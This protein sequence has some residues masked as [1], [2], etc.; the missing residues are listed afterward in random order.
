M[1][2]HL[3]N[4]VLGVQEKFETFIQFPSRD[5]ENVVEKRGAGGVTE[6]EGVRTRG[7]REGH[8]GNQNH[9]ISYQI[10]SLNLQYALKSHAL[11]ICFLRKA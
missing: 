3:S 1:T 8:Y 11:Q 9:P 2:H 10:A 5:K 4:Q 7:L 6:R